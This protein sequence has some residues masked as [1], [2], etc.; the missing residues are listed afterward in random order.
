MDSCVIIG[1]LCMS[2]AC[3][4]TH[5]HFLGLWLNWKMCPLAWPW[6]PLG[7]LCAGVVH[8]FCLKWTKCF[9]FYDYM[10]SEVSP[11]NQ[12]PLPCLW[13]VPSNKWFPRLKSHIVDVRQMSCTLELFVWFIDTVCYG[14][15]LWLWVLACI[16]F[17]SKRM[18]V[19]C[20]LWIRDSNFLK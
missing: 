2:H 4:H 5:T 20:L 15:G 14:Y 7:V 9:I 3:T 12:G 8:L 10:K 6:T 13:K 19:H 1:W 18:Y 11:E 16:R 17:Y